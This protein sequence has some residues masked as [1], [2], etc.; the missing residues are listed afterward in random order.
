MG[1]LIFWCVFVSASMCLHAESLQ[2]MNFLLN[3]PDQTVVEIQFSSDT[4]S[5]ELV[6]KQTL[7]YSDEKPKVQHLRGETTT[8]GKDQYK[9][10]LNSN[11]SLNLS[12]DSEGFY[13]LKGLSSKKSEMICEGQSFS[14]N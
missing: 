3:C 9:L 13:L 1:K 6:Q 11:E 2:D 8:L 7:S 5:F 14:V 4:R 12:K 10:K